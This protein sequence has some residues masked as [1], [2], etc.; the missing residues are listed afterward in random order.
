[1]AI[2]LDP[3]GLVDDEI[4]SKFMTDTNTTLSSEFEDFCGCGQCFDC[5]LASPENNYCESCEYGVCHTHR[6]A[7]GTTNCLCC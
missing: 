2:T 1:M 3:W 7:D 6:K 4:Y 5:N